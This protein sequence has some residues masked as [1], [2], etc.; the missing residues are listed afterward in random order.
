M[1]TLQF[2]LCI[3]LLISSTSLLAQ[4]VNIYTKKI[5]TNIN[6]TALLKLTI[7]SVEIESSPD[8]NFYIEYNLN[9]KNYSERKR[10]KTIKR[11]L[12]KVKIKADINN[13]HIT[14]VDNTI[15]YLSNFYYPY[16]Q[17]N[18][19]VIENK[20]TYKSKNIFLEEVKEKSKPTSVT[21]DIINRT[22][23]FSEQQKKELIN[24]IENKRKKMYTKSFVIKIPKNLKVT[25]DA[26]NAKVRINDNLSNKLSIR[27]SRGKLVA[28]N[29][30]NNNNVIKVKDAS[31]FVENINGGELSINNVRK[32]LI[33]SINEVN[34]SSEF[35]NF[36]IGEIKQNNTIKGFSNDIIIHNF[37]NSFKKF[38]VTLEY[39]KF[40]FFDL[41]NDYQL[42]IYGHNT[43]VD[44]NNDIKKSTSSKNNTKNAFFVKKS[45]NKNL[46]SG[47]INLN[48]N[49]SFIYIR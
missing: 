9:F 39:S 33:G 44:N 40:R 5:E 4:K 46:S 23:R 13:N 20:I 49:H 16:W 43:I 32:G 47:T 48:T 21:S 1:K 24:D 10:K 6:T 12:E 18:D 34:L 35:S 11:F 30:S 31:F 15:F 25:I 22:T 7:G 36:E 45:N 17:K 38:D 37:S 42:N 2:K 41:T 19:T 26:K 27:L 3:L 14:L 28:K 29:L 8:E